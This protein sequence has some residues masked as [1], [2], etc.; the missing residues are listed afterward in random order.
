[1]TKLNKSIIM[2]LRVDVCLL[3]DTILLLEQLGHTCENKSEAMNLALEILLQVTKSSR[4]ETLEDSYKILNDRGLLDMNSNKRIAKRL[5]Q[6][7]GV[8]NVEL[9]KVSSI[10]RPVGDIAN[11]TGIGF[12]S[13]E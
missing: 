1:M 7:I 10:T 3:A 5:V 2:S 11:L 6:S 12:K 4:T 9:D 13:K 8:E